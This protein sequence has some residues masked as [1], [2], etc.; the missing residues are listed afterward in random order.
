MSPETDFSDT[1]TYPDIFIQLLDLVQ[2]G[3]DLLSDE[4]SLVLRFYFE[5]ECLNGD[6]SWLREVEAFLDFSDNLV[7]ATGTRSVKELRINPKELSNLADAIFSRIEDGS[8]RGWRHAYALKQAICV[9]GL[10]DR[11]AMHLRDEW[12]IDEAVSLHLLNLIWETSP[13]SDYEK[14][15]SEIGANAQSPDLR[16]HAIQRLQAMSGMQSKR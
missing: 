12:R 7:K 10:Q 14:T 6:A 13:S 3:E 5:R 4:A 16:E 8:A 2:H 15:L 9:P 1:E 11:A